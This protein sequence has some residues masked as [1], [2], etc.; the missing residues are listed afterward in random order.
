MNKTELVGVSD[1]CLSCNTSVVND[2]GA[3]KFAC[4]SCGQYQVVRCAKCRKIV[5]KYVCPSCQ[6]EGPN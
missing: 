3:A 4:P 5:T 1:K 6:F 2:K